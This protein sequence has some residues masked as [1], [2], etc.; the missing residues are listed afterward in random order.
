MM[1]AGEMYRKVIQDLAR[2]SLFS[3]E[4]VARQSVLLAIRAKARTRNPDSRSS[5]HR[6][7]VGYYLVA[8]GSRMLKERIGYKALMRQRILDAI[9]EWPEVFFVVGVELTT[10]VLVY[11]LLRHLGVIVPLLPG[12]LLL[13]PASHAAIGIV[14]SLTGMVVPPRQIP[15]L[16]YSEGIPEECYDARRG[17]LYAVERSRGAAQCRYPGNPLSGQS[18]PPS[19]FRPLDRFARRLPAF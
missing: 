3:E 17:A 8:A 19:P 18:R 12:L 9:L 13:I 5:S 15:K 10:L 11:F 16:D 6:T 4:E 2:Q 1:R 7:H 14:N